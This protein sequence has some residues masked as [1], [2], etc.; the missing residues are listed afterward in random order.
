MAAGYQ[1]LLIEQGT[2]YSTTITLDD[3]NGNIYNLSNYYAES[4]IRKS[5][6]SANTAGVFNVTIPSVSSGQ[7]VISM[8]ASNTANIMPGRYVYDVKLV[9]STSPDSDT[10]RILEGIVE[11]SPQV[12]R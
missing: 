6:Y 12:T 11:I 9:S 4:Q 1:N 8:T 10:V 7:I 5:Y 3:T 2:S